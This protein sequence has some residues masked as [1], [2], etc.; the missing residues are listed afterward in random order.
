MNYIELTHITEDKLE[1]C[2]DSVE[3]VFNNNE[4]PQTKYNVFEK[5][6]KAAGIEVTSIKDVTP[7]PHNGCRPPKRRRV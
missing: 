3:D 7:I 6:I 4:R 1:E 5:Q 2:I